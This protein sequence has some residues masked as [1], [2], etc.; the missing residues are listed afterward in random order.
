MFS[1]LFPGLPDSVPLQKIILFIKQRDKEYVKQDAL[2][3][4]MLALT[5]LDILSLS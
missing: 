4:T 3:G 5:L 1:T 2:I